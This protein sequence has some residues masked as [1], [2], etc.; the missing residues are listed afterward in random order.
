MCVCETKVPHGFPWD[1][2]C[3]MGMVKCELYPWEACSNAFCIVCIQHHGMPY[4]ALKGL[5]SPP[6]GPLC[7]ADSAAVRPPWALSRHSII[8]LRGLFV[9]SFSDSCSFHG[10]E[11]QQLCAYFLWRLVS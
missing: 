9:M 5:G 2:P 7:S 8:V 10:V 1:L 6:M 4:G 3:E 11:A